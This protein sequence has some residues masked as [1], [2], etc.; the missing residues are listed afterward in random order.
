MLYLDTIARY[1]KMRRICRAPAELDAVAQ[2]GLRGAGT[3]RKQTTD[4]QEF[5]QSH[6]GMPEIVGRRIPDI[7]PGAL[8][9]H[10]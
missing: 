4:E 8:T 2:A 1:H 3:G 6:E 5:I 7:G 9:M 10:P